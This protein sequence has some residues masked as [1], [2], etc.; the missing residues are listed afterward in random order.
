MR[1]EALGVVMLPRT[2]YKAKAA[3]RGTLGS[4]LFN[5]RIDA[6]LFEFLG[7]DPD[8]LLEVVRTANDD[9]EIEAYVRDF[10]AA[11]TAAE[12]AA[13][14]ERMLNLRVRPES[15]YA[16]AFRAQRERIAPERTYVTTW[17]D[18]FELEEGR[19]VPRR[20]ASA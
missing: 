14:N 7:L 13:F 11:K 17:A 12:V 15:P 19:D 2:I 5:Y 20:V 1:A 10:V 8:E 16:P 9:A 3:V 6:M 18:L 4:Y